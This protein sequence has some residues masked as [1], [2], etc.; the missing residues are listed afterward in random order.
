MQ[1]QQT[2]SYDKQGHDTDKEKE[3]KDFVIDKIV[4]H[5]IKKSWKQSYAEYG[6]LIFVCLFELKL[7]EDT[8]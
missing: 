2:E 5:Q 4:N 6:E 3:T 1:E 7:K 8:W